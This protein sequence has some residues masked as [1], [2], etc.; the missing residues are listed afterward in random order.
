MIDAKDISP[1]YEN[2]QWGLPS[3]IGKT[4]GT[5]STADN[6]CDALGALWNCHV[7]DRRKTCICRTAIITLSRW[8]CETHCFSRHFFCERLVPLLPESATF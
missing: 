8:R 4:A 6:S 5:V 7:K 2:R 1:H 3:L